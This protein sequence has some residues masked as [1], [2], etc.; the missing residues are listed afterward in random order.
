[1]RLNAQIIKKK[2]KNEY[3]VIP[4]HEFLKLQEE[5]H[6]YEDLRCL[7]EAKA[8]DKDFPTISIDE[9]KKRTVGR[10]SGCTGR[11]APVSLLRWAHP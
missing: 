4:Y 11:F 3:A 5:L 10:T 2:G 9:V 8:V 7:R 6:N 1:M